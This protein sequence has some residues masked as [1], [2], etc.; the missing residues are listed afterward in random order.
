MHAI[1]MDKLAI[2]PESSERWLRFIFPPLVI[3]ALLIMALL[4]LAILLQT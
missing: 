3:L 2:G 1:K 4:T